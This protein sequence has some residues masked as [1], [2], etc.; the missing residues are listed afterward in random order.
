M[1]AKCGHYFR[2][3]TQGLAEC[4]SCSLVMLRPEWPAPEVPCRP[5][6]EDEIPKGAKSMLKLAEAND[7]EIVRSTYAKGFLPIAINNWT[8]GNS[9]ESFVF[10]A[11]REDLR[12]C[13]AWVSG[14]FS[15]SYV[16]SVSRGE[17]RKLNSTDL[18]SVLKLELS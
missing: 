5:A 2:T 17:Y 4:V 16:R 3:N 18:R 7:W 14:S 11:K 9:V 8:P 13:A 12:V 1:A 6:T 15:F 10:G